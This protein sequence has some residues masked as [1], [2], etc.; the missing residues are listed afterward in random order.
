MQNFHREEN[1]IWD[2]LRLTGVAVISAFIVAAV[3]IGAGGAVLPAL[4]DEPGAAPII[5]VSADR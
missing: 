1:D 5:R 3:V 2:A 4:L